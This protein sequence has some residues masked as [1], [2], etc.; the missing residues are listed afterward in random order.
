MVDRYSYQHSYIPRL[1]YPFLIPSFTEDVFH[2]QLQGLQ[3]QTLLLSNSDS[4]KIQMIIKST[5]VE[6]ERCLSS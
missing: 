1:H 5:K 4:S 6:L 2:A 3:S